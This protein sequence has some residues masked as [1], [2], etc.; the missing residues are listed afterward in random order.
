M[1]SGLAD[2][3]MTAQAHPFVVG[4][5]TFSA[6]GRDRGH[7]RSSQASPHQPS[8]GDADLA[9][10]GL[11]Q[12]PGWD[13]LRHITLLLEIESTLGVKF[14]SSEMGAIHQ[15]PSLDALVRSK[16]AQTING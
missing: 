6:R 4:G 3:K 2:R 16:L 12:T 14:A 9:Q 11:G 13:S 8:E 1:R 15:F 7:E 10:A 5:R